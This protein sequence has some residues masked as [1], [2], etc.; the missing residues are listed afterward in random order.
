MSY[1]VAVLGATGMVG[2]EIMNCLAERDFPVKVLQAYASRDSVGKKMSFGDLKTVIVQ[3]L[4]DISLD[5]LDVVF[6]SLTDEMIS[7]Y[8]HVLEEAV[9][10]GCIVIDTSSIYR[11]KPEVPLV[12]PEIN[13]ASVRLNEQ[14]KPDTI[15][16]NP[17]CSAIQ[18]ALPLSVVESVCNIDRVF[19]STYQSTSGAGKQAMDA[20]YDGTKAMFMPY[21]DDG[22]DVALEN[23]AFNC[24]PMIGQVNRYGHSGEEEKIFH[25][26]RKILD[27]EIDVNATCVRVPTFIGHG[28]A[29][30]IEFLDLD[31]MN[32]QHVLGEVID[33]FY[34]SE[35]LICSNSLDK[36]YTIESAR[37]YDSVGISRLRV[38]TSGQGISFWSVCNNIR[39]GAALNAV[40]I[41]EHFI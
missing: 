2:R 14:G 39:K 35:Y 1:N 23:N 21:Q 33:L 11:L 40:Q 20:L 36:Y 8:S 17:N 29:V 37:N 6:S 5:G 12:V 10:S 9:S 18:L 16:A 3:D 19:V 30:S 28:Q 15:I 26:I 34:D 7:K 38:S 41:V 13:I 31:E 25:E 22:S 32:V 4:E 27:V 24:I